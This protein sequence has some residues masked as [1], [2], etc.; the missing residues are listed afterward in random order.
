MEVYWSED[1][2]INEY[3]EDMTYEDI[4]FVISL[5]GEKPESARITSPNIRF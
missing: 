3:C 1:E 2:Y 5:P 4:K